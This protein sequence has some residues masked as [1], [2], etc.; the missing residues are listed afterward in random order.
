MKL[1]VILLCLLS[2]RYLVHSIAYQRFFWF[3]DYYF[4]DAGLFVQVENICCAD[5]F[6]GAVDF[7]FGV[8]FFN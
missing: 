2:E 4:F 5:D 1:M 3:G 6:F 8:D 7:D